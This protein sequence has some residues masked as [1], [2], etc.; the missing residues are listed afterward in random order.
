MSVHSPP[1]P[2]LAR[3]SPIE[4]EQ[5]IV[6]VLRN[7]IESR[8]R[9]AAISLTLSHR[10]KTAEIEILDDG[11]GIAAADRDHLFEPFFSTRTRVGGTGLGLS[12]A[13]GVMMDHGGQIRIES[14]PGEGTRVVI[15]LPIVDEA[16]SEAAEEDGLTAQRAARSPD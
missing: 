13:H 16:T 2:L 1:Q 15:S 5:A 9:D 8:E 3:I 10:D 11:Q 14:V 6:N 12:V 7:A 4:V